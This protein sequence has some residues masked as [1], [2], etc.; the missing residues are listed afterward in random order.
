[1]PT[2]LS[3]DEDGVPPFAVSVFSYRTSMTTY[4]LLMPNN[5]S[6]GGLYRVNMTSNTTTVI[7]NVEIPTNLLGFKFWVYVIDG[8]GAMG[9]GDFF[10]VAPGNCTIANPTTYRIATQSRTTSQISQTLRYA[11]SPQFGHSDSL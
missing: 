7:W 10:T 6:A 8:E 11:Q 1:M 2:L 4:V 5:P 9:D 3:W